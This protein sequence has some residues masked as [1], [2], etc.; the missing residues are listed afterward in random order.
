M[1]NRF[2]AINSFTLTND[3]RNGHNVLPAGYTTANPNISTNKIYFLSVNDTTLFR[4]LAVNVINRHSFRITSVAA[5]QFVTNGQTKICLQRRMIR[6]GAHIVVIPPVNVFE[7]YKC[8]ILVYSR[9][10]RVD[11]LWAE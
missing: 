6:G 1:C 9:A 2:Y 4:Q 10:H 11:L 5:V 3:C 8:F 7:H